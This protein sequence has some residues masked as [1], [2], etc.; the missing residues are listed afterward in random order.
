MKKLLDIIRSWFSKP[1]LILPSHKP[2]T[3]ILIYVGDTVVGAVQSLS[4]TEIRRTDI[5]APP[6]VKVNAYR[7]RFDKERVA[8]AFSR[9]FIHSNAQ[10][11]PFQIHIA[12]DNV[13][14][15]IQNAWIKELPG[16]TY[17]VDGWSIVEEMILEAETI[18]SKKKK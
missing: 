16:Y 6:E 13:I 14:T 18:F 12:D 2:S 11:R 7:I 3:K 15:T 5:P 8:E 4:I 1:A 9:G 17:L 10:I